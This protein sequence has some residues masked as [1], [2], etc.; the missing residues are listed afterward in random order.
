L[1][2]RCALS[3]GL[4]TA[5]DL[6][7]DMTPPANVNA[8]A[9]TLGGWTGSIGAASAL[10]IVDGAVSVTNDAPGLFPVG[11]TTVTWSATDVAGTRA[12]R[13]RR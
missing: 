1:A 11:V 8:E 12:R 7:I 6:Y 9:N 2:S 3:S 10:D 4:K 13:R 5:A